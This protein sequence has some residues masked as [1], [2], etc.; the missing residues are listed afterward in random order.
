MRDE[1]SLN[2][3]MV[4]EVVDWLRQASQLTRGQDLEMEAMALSDLGKVYHKVSAPLSHA[5]Y[6]YEVQ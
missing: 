5:S 6:V 2:M 4:W 1:E 3:D